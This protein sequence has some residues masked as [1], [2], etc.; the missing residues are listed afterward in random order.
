MET[1]FARPQPFLILVFPC[2]NEE[3]QLPISLKIISGFLQKLKLEN[4]ISEKSCAC[5]VDDG[6]TDNT[7][8]ILED[9]HK[10]EPVSHAI[11]FAGNAGQQNALW[12]GMAYAYK[13]GCDCAITMDVD[14]QDDINVIAD[15]VR[16]YRSG[17]DIVYGVRNDRHTDSFFKR[18]TA[19]LFYSVISKFDVSM[20]PNHADFRLLDNIALEALTHF[21]ERNLYI[22][23]LMPKLGFKTAKV[24]YMRLTRAAGETKYSAR[25]MLSLAWQGIT[26]CS[27]AP[28]RFA[29]LMGL[30]SML[31]SVILAIYFI[32]RKY[33]YG[34]DVQ[35][36]TSLF[37]AILFMGAVQLFSLAVI[38]EYIAKIYTEVRRRPR[39]IIEKEF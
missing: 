2:Y 14:L 11:K 6:S 26:S 9:Y 30:L 18:Q 37:I 33:I 36:W 21:E 35:G 27:I 3:K 10:Q 20:I 13:L 17:H 19:N 12:A 32:C 8:A 28:L 22:R 23:G 24:Y 34:A 15:M 29:G 16:E 25:K 5:F 7:W 4:I 38:G 1:S 31:L 39:Y